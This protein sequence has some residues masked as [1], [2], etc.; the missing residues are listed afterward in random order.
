MNNGFAAIS[1]AT[2]AP[3]GHRPA[4]LNSWKEIAVYL[5]RGVRTV[6]RWHID[7]ELPVHRVTASARSPVFAF[8]SEVDS[9]LGRCAERDSEHNPNHRESHAETTLSREFITGSVDRIFSVAI[10]QQHRVATLLERIKRLRESQARKHGSG[11]SS[12]QP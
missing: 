11:R 12:T 3:V 2:G 4:V 9:W 6:Q 5:G 8:S 1:P 10:D 7:S